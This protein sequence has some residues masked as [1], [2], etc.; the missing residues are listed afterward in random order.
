MRPFLLNNLAC[1][2]WWHL[3]QFRKST[4]K[5]PE[6]TQAISDFKSCVPN[7]QRAISLFDGKE[8][9]LHSLEAKVPTSANSGI[10]L[11]NVAEVLLESGNQETLQWWRLALTHSKQHRKEE[12][13]RILAHLA[14][15]LIREDKQ[16][17]EEII[18]DAYKGLPT[19]EDCRTAFVL[20]VHMKI[21]GLDSARREELDTLWLRLQALNEKIPFW[22][23]PGVHLYVPEWHLI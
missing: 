17:A 6:V 15:M 10:A 21:I 16:R 9:T 5:G 14:D 7:L 23:W 8:N 11:C 22:A 1:A 2:Q 18:K 13:C 19:V 4:D 20:E 12:L 3:L